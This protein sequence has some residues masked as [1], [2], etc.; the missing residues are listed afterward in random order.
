M[1]TDNIAKPKSEAKRNSEPS[2]DEEILE[3]AVAVAAHRLAAAEAKLKAF[4]ARA[5]TPP[6][7]TAPPPFEPR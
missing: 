3:A 2:E 4:R 7:F 5:A 6:P 1:A